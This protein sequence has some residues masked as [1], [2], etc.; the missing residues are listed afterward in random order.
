MPKLKRV[1]GGDVLTS[2]E[3][4]MCGSPVE[5]SAMLSELKKEA[6][7]TYSRQRESF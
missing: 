6:P 1:R 5:G 3:G 7:E 2:G 4:S